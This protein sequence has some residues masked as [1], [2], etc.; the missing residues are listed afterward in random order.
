MHKHSS[1][2]L[3]RQATLRVVGLAGLS[4][5][6]KTTL[7]TAVLP[8]LIARGLRV[9]TLKHAHHA[10]DIDQPGKDSYRHRQ[11]GARQVLIASDRRWALM[12]EHDQ[13][14]APSLPALIAQLHDNDLVVVEGFKRQPFPKLLIHR[15]AVHGRLCAQDLERFCDL[16]AIASDTPVQCQDL[17]AQHGLAVLALDDLTAI[18]DCLWQQAIPA[19]T[20]CTRPT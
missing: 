15:Q 7:L 16:C 8:A 9:S 4:G 1:S 14:H 13:G 20:L 3:P 6:G 10:F 17:A 12:S 19:E 5:S 2:P 11:A 18:A